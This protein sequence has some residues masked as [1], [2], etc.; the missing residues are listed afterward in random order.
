MAEQGALRSFLF[1]TGVA[2]AGVATGLAAVETRRLALPLAAVLL[3]VSIGAILSSVPA[4]A[5]LVALAVV[6]GSLLDLPNSMSFAGFTGQSIVTT[7]VVFLA[8]VV[9]LTELARVPV[10]ARKAVATLSVFTVYAGVSLLWASP[11]LSALQNLFVFALFPLAIACGSLAATTLPDVVTLVDHVILVAVAV[12]VCLGLVQIFAGR[13]VGPRSFALFALVPLSWNLAFARN[14]SRRHMAIAAILLI[15]IGAT[16]SRAALATGLILACIS[17]LDLRT[18]SRVARFAAAAI[19]VV[20]VAYWA[21][22]SYT[23]LKDRFQQGDVQ[24]VGG[25]PVNVSGREQL[26]SYT[27]DGFLNRPIFGH[28]LGESER[29]IEAAFAQGH[30]HNDYLRILYDLGLVGLAL[31]MLAYWQLFSRV[32]ANRRRM[33]DREVHVAALL[34]LI[35]VALSMVTDNEIVYSF[36]MG[37]A[38]VVIG[39][40]LG[41]DA[42]GAQRSD[43]ANSRQ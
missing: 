12:S 32:L 33:P 34:V 29:A 28:G 6:Q 11:T 9:V 3:A 16:L 14:G 5:L 1:T 7:I 36:V 27:W 39:L 31:W 38:G 37:P 10:A 25:V 15:C 43:L 2:M 8:G 17:L 30:P 23:P 22:T 20:G 18:P 40:S 4:A 42:M 26:W 35:A 24:T 13:L 21:A 19:L 41:C